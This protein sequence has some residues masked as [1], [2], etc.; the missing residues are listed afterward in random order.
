MVGRG[1]AE[2]GRQYVVQVMG[3]APGQ[4]AQAVHLLGLLQLGHELCQS[5]LSQ[6][7]L[8]DI[9]ARAHQVALALGLEADGCEVEGYQVAVLGHHGSLQGTLPL[10]HDLWDGRQCGGPAFL[11]IP[12]QDVSACQVFRVEPEE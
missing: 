12:V 9:S 2:D 8:T 1:K 4:A 10:F 6:L 11:G 3:Q 5:Q 7:S